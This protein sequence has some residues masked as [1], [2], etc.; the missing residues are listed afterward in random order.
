LNFVD[1]RI[2][3]QFWID[4]FGHIHKFKGNPENAISIHYEIAQTIISD[5]NYPDDVLMNRGWI[6][7]FATGYNKPLINKTPTQAQINVLYSLGLYKKLL[8]LQSN[9]HYNKF[10][11][12]L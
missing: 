7:T 6:K 4:T 9:G 11:P 5:S 12:T 3:N 2:E 1:K 8:I 10:M